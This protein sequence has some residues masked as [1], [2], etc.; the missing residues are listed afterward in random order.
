VKASAIRES[1]LSD[2]VETFLESKKDELVSL[3]KTEAVR[4]IEEQK[5]LQHYL[6]QSESQ[7]MNLEKSIKHKLT[8]LEGFEADLASVPDEL[9]SEKDRLQFILEKQTQIRSVLQDSESDL[10]FISEKHNEFRGY[11]QDCENQLCELESD[12][13]GKV[14]ASAKIIFKSVTGEFENQKSLWLR[15][16]DHMDPQQLQQQLLAH[17][18]NIPVAPTD[19]P[20]LGDFAR[21]TIARGVDINAQPEAAADCICGIVDSLF[22]ALL[23]PLITALKP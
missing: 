21:S 14:A 6:Q 17:T 2:S 8:S 23:V 1:T 19:M 9:E 20:L 12:F 16:L 7:F 18:P 4:M 11:L 5:K 15:R 10:R 3:V 13:K 22:K